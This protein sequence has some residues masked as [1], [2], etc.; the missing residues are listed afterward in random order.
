VVLAAGCADGRVAVP[1]VS[2]DEAGRQALAEYDRNND[3]FLDAQELEKCPAL[4]SSLSILDRDRDGRLSG[5]EIADRVAGYQEAKVGLVSVSCPVLLDGQP[6][7]GATVTLT[8]ETFL[9]SGFKPASGVSDARGTVR[10]RT[11]GEEVPGVQCGF[12]RIT[13]SKTDAGGRELIPARYNRQTTLGQ[14]VAPDTVGHSGPLLLR[15]SSR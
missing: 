2:P 14:E 8:P 9:G 6:L 5:Q 3:G 11:E 1:A 4:K 10:L 13:V 7:E 15:L 12:F